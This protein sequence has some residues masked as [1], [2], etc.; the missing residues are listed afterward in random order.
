[1]TK[2][3]LNPNFY[4]SKLTW[5]NKENWWTNKLFTCLPLRTDDHILEWS[6]AL[7]TSVI[8]NWK[9]NNP[10]FDAVNDVNQDFSLKYSNNKMGI[11]DVFNKLS[12]NNT[13]ANVLH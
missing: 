1:M 11:N 6:R 7:D 2:R 12:I 9:I 3:I 4:Y 13:R 8:D 10:T 5:Y